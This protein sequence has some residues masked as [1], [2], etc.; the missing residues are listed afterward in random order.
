MRTSFN[1]KNIRPKRYLLML[2]AVML[3]TQFLACSSK[4]D[5]PAPEDEFNVNFQL[6]KSIEVSKGGEYTFAVREG[7]G[8]IAPLT[9]DSFLL[10]S[11]AGISYLCPIVNS[12]SDGFT[13]RVADECE[14]GYYYA[15]I[16]RGSR[17]KNLGQ[18][19]ISIV[20]DI[21]FEPDAGTTV[22]GIVSSDAGPVA[23][24][25]VS[26]GVE[27]TRTNEQG[28]YQLRSEKK[29]GYVFIS[30]P[31][32]YEVPSSGVLPILHCNLKG[33]SSTVERA[34]FSL[35]KVNQDSYK[36]F[37]LGDMHLADR[38]SDIS[39]FN[40]FTADL[41]SYM[42]GHSSERL[43]AITLGDMT[44]DLYWYSNAFSFPQYLDIAN[45]QLIGLQMFHTMGNH[46]NDFK[47]RNDFDAATPYV[48]N[49]APTYYSF[50]IGKIHYVVLDDID[51][52]SY[53][54]TESRN[55]KKNVSTEQ[56]N[57][58]RKDLSYVD[59][60]TPII[61]TMHAQLYKPATMAG[62]FEYDHDVANSETLLNILEGYTVHFVTGHTHRMFN[63]T[64][65]DDVTGGRNIYEHNSGAICA[66]WWWSGYLTPGV[67]IGEE[68]TPGGYGIWDISGTEIKY[69]YKATGWPEDYQ[70]RC[71]DLNSISFSMND[72]PLCPSS[73]KSSFQKYV[74]AYPPS[75][76]N[77]VLINIWNWNRNWKLTVTDEREKNLEY[78]Q[79]NAYDPLHIAAL[80]IPRFN[81]PTISS[82]PNF[83]TASYPHFFKVTADDANVDLTI[84]VEDEFGTV[85]SEKMQRP[86][87]FTIDAYKNK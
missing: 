87:E 48:N 7:G 40:D 37:M 2:L 21:G 58:L 25:V 34:D 76:K 44:W 79:V 32:G 6:P 22:Y 4:E 49:I 26:D 27:V 71:Y 65:Q 62:K 39:Q 51:C 36:V 86:M 20:E 80:T 45:K 17:K 74:N 16:R 63:V 41:R 29:W 28:I 75:D 67:H 8:E 66:S 23:N 35:K 77:E 84:R 3:Q 53:D 1:M 85:W 43:Y 83:I 60:N 9:S 14:S 73:V 82:A 57:W 10:E 72:I 13:I 46:D 12:T 52:S 18:L 68:G 47:A 33:S 64:P 61:V 15:S 38:T 81:V 56:L 50:N 55:Y 31:G 11:E 70:F 54:G 59:K 19:Y 42:S 78:Q 24:V 69:S 5:S 30:I